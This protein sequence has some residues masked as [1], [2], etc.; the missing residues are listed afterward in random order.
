MFFMVLS[1]MYSVLQQHLL[2]GKK[3]VLDLESWPLNATAM[4]PAAVFRQKLQEKL[5]NPQAQR[6][7]LACRDHRAQRS[8]LSISK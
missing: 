5:E 4:T 2:R 7:I 3:C 6:E 8:S 1:I